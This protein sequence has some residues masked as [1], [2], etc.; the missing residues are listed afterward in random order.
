MMFMF[1]CVNKQPHLIMSSRDIERTTATLKRYKISSEMFVFIE[2]PSCDN[3]IFISRDDNK[4]ALV[5]SKQ[6]IPCF[7]PSTVEALLD[8][9]G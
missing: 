2:A 9:R 4:R 5:R 8:W 7:H 3:A 1:Q 6:K